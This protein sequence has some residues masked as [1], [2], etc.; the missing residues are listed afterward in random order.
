MKIILAL[1]LS[2]S[3]T[4]PSNKE[5][6]DYA[7]YY[8]VEFVD[9]SINYK[10]KSSDLMVL[11]TGNQK[12]R[13]QSYYKHQRDSLAELAKEQQMEP[14]ALIPFLN[15]IQKPKFSYV[16]SKDWVNSTYTYL[17]RV[18]PDYFIFTESLNSNQWEILEEYDVYMGY[19]VQKAITKY[20]GRQFEAWFTEEI[21]INDGPYVFGNLPG[22]IVRVTDTQYH[23]DFKMVK[24]EKKS[25]PLAYQRFRKTIKTSKS[26]FFKALLDFNDNVLGKMAM[27]GVTLTDKCQSKDVQERYNKKNN[28]LELDV[29][30]K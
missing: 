2:I 21:P 9:D 5:L 20:G 27:G 17:D 6:S 18:F 23:Y 11:F 12:S 7:I 28:P 24:I 8:E 26:H 25:E 10:D 14:N 16:I 30:R 29:L 1:I 22:L 3:F 13:F 4:F 19:K 15:Q